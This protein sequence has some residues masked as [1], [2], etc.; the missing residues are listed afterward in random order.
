MRGRTD[1][2]DQ[3]HGARVVKVFEP[4]K[5]VKR[6]IRFSLRLNQVRSAGEFHRLLVDEARALCGAQRVLLVLQ[7]GPEIEPAS[8]HLPA[9]ED[10]TVLLAAI[11]P[12]LEEARRTRAVRLRHGPDGARDVDQRSCLIAPLVARRDLLGF[13]Y[14]DVEGT[15]GRF[16]SSDVDF[17]TLLGEHFA[18]ALAFR[19][20]EED[21]DAMQER[22]TATAEVLQVISN[23]VEDTQPVFEKIL[24][25]CERLFGTPNLGIVVVHDDGL[26]H[27]AAIRGSV[28]QT[29]TRTLPMPVESSTTGRAM[30]ERSIVQIRDAAALGATS[31]WARDT[32]QQVGNFSAAWV[33]MLWEDRGIG[34][35]MVV[36][37]P[38]SP[39]SNKDEALLRTFADQA[40]IA[41]QNARLFNETR[42][43]LERQTATAR[44]LS[45]LSGSMTDARPV[46]DAIV[47]SCRSLFDDSVVALRLVRDGVLHVEANIGMDSGPLPVDRSS[48]VG[49]CV[50]EGRILHFPDLEASATQ[51]SRMR[52]L[53]LKQGYRSAIF[54]PLL[55]AGEAIGTIGIFRR[56]P[57]AFSDKDVA[58]LGT[59]ADQAVIAIENVRL[60]NETREALEQQTATAEVLQ[61]ISSSVSDTAPV[62]DKIL[63]SCRHLFGSTQVG[64]LLAG[65][66]G[67]V[68]VGAWR[69]SAR[70]AMYQAFPR[71]FEN[72]ITAQAIRERRTVHIAD[73]AAMPN[74]PPAVGRVVEL[75]GN[76]SV[77]WAPMLW[78]DEGVGAICIMRQP[79]SPFSNKELALLKTFADQAVIAIQNARLFN[80]T[81]EALEHQTATSEVLQVISESMADATPVFEKI[82]DRC[83][84]LFGATNL[85]VFLVDAQQRLN[86]GAYRGSFADWVPGTYPRA[87]AG[88]MSEKVIQNG[89]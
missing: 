87:L 43:S 45:A 25:S 14:L 26:V 19:R 8:W 30:R 47:E 36:R 4:G 54:A 15:S 56:Q 17:V 79:P 78:K 60:F 88:T 18:T 21:V 61:V 64:V 53:A 13:L 3:A 12:W 1:R 40:V 71:P 62:F 52:G 23:S 67:Q 31:E 84:R 16:D 80:D 81:K 85:G 48:A 57:G 6:L 22:Q 77:A 7:V 74:P 33:P 32:V 39:F 27:P 69:G 29:M 11:A 73:V 20:A 44:I 66:D 5:A 82:L 59:F 50:L 10:A 41:I 2:P 70:E 49:T 9:G 89:P 63:D 83:E 46:F 86:V 75:S 55:R 35:I 65:E 38:P 76:C 37:Q 34:S 58:L 28:V 24:D 68:H 51:F 42:E 72:S